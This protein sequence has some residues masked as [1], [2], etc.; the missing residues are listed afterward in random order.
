MVLILFSLV[1]GCLYGQND[2]FIT[3]GPNRCDDNT[4]STL[5]DDVSLVMCV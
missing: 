1:V 5:T 3:M 4:H 2:V